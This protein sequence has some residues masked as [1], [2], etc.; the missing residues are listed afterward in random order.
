MLVVVLMVGVYRLAAQ[1]KSI[2]SSHTET[3]NTPESSVDVG[4]RDLVWDNDASKENPDSEIPPT[5]EK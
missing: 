1:G 5:I 2:S 3:D 4:N